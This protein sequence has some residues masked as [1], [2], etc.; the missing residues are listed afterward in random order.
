[1]VKVGVEMDVFSWDGFLLLAVTLVFAFLWHRWLPSFFQASI[2]SAITVVVCVQLAYFIRLNPFFR[3]VDLT[4]TV[5]AL[6]A[7]LM[8][9]I[10]FQVRRNRIKRNSD[11]VQ[12]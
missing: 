3:T 4:T 1:M 12:H 2:G 7:S 11:A 10:P 5:I 6:V 9:G 8:V